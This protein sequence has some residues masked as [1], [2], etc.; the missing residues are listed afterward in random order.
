MLSSNA[1]LLVLRDSW[2]ARIAIVGFFSICLALFSF[3]AFLEQDN[4]LGERVFF[5]AFALGCAIAL[6]RA[7]FVDRIVFYA[8]RLSIGGP[9]STRNFGHEDIESFFPGSAGRLGIELRDGSREQ[10]RIQRHWSR[11]Q[12]FPTLLNYCEHWLISPSLLSDL[13]ALDRE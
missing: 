7:Q 11:S 10:A 13:P 6:Y 5:G 3:G 9:L 2:S 1:E 12:N 8:D 4:S